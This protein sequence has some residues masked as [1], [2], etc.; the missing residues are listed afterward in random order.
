MQVLSQNY[1]FLAQLNYN[2]KYWNN[3]LH[4]TTAKI[5][6]YVDGYQHVLEP[7]FNYCTLSNTKAKFYD[8]YK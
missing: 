5:N 1:R 3:F 6:D 2:R 4:F 8:N 7:L